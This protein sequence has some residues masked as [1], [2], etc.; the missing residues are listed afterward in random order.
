M[1]IAFQS[2]NI[3]PD[4]AFNRLEQFENPDEFVR[5]VNTYLQALWQAKTDAKAMV[6]LEEQV[7]NQDLLLFAAGERIK[8]LEE[9]LTKAMLIARTALTCMNQEDLRKFAYVSDSQA[10]VGY[11]SAGC[12]CG[13]E[14]GLRRL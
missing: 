8:Q 7:K 11:G 1:M 5:F 2:A 9:S 12:R 6:K 10:A 3:N 14:T 4:D 13:R